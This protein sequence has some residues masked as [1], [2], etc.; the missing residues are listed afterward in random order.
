M[1]DVVGQRRVE[2]RGGVELLAGD[3][4]P[5]DRK[6]AGADDRANAESGERPRPQRLLQPMLRILRFRDQL[7]DGLAREELVRQVKAPG[8]RGMSAS[9]SKQMEAAKGKSGQFQ[10]VDA[11]CLT[12]EHTERAEKVSYH[13]DTEA[14]S[15]FEY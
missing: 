3:G 10:R 14:P 13:R 6:N 12:T 1:H 11:E 8:S 9:E 4:G 15:L 5:D 2:N 7:V